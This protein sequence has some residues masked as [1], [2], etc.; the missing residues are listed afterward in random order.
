MPCGAF[1]VTHERGQWLARLRAELETSRIRNELSVPVGHG[2]FAQADKL[3]AQ[4][5]GSTQ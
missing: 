1:D 3:R 2:A 5:A 4:D